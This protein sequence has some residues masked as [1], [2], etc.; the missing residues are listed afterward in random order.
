MTTVAALA[1]VIVVAGQ[2]WIGLAALV[3]GLVASVGVLWAPTASLLGWLVMEPTMRGTVGAVFGGNLPALTPDRGLLALLTVVVAIR[4]ARRPGAFRPLGRIELAMGAFLAVAAI[5]M[6]VRGG[7]QLTFQEG[8]LRRDFIYLVLGYAI[9]FLAFFLAKNL[10]RGNRHLLWVLYTLIALGVVLGATG[11]AQYAGGATF[12][13]PERFAHIH[14]DRATGTLESAVEFGMLIAS[15]LLAAV[16]L[17]LRTRTLPRGVVLVAAI[18]WFVV[19]V[20]LSETR[21]IF[22]GI[23]LGLAVAAYYEP[24]FRRPLLLIGVLAAVAGLAAYELAPETNAVKSRVTALEPIYNRVALAATALNMIAQKPIFGYGFGRYTFY[25]DKRLLITSMFGVAPYYA[26]A[27]TVPHNE[28]LH[29]LVL[30]GLVGFIPYV[31]VLVL[32]WRTAARCYRRYASVPG[33]ARDISLTLLAVLAMYLVNGLLTDLMMQYSA[34][35]QVYLLLG[36]VDGLRVHADA[37]RGAA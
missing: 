31:A 32:A 28:F 21:S 6:L 12:F 34:S 25:E 10:L 29:V 19:A 1:L 14:G 16:I 33:P 35:G 36:A 13:L 24:R 18:A 9:P 3:G 8:G 37:H 5:S 20:I 15:A 27:Q 26:W 22:V 7:S 23:A 30:V 17:L 4:W 2:M 11:I